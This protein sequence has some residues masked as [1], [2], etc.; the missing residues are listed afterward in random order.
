MNWQG[1][2]AARRLAASHVGAR[3]NAK[4]WRN[5]ALRCVQATVIAHFRHC[6]SKLSRRSEC[7]LRLGHDNE[8]SALTSASS[9]VWRS[10][11][12]DP[13]LFN[14]AI[15]SGWHG[16]S[17]LCGIRHAA[18]H[19]CAM[20]TGRS[21]RATM[22]KRVEN[23]FAACLGLVFACVA[24]SLPAAA[25]DCASRW[26]GETEIAICRDPQLSRSEDQITRRIAGFARRISFGQYLSLRHWHALWSEERSRCSS[27]RSCMVASY[28]VQ[29]RF[30]DRLQQCLD[31]SPQRR[32]CFR[33]TLTV[34][35]QRR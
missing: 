23:G 30:L 25:L 10:A 20:E 18:Q 17:L 6:V 19:A 34:E 15:G 12:C 32:A 28:R 14:P 26:L 1:T 8:H 4:S 24:G 21:G 5:S 35:A 16:R 33:G 7:P 2:Y 27:E 29:T 22:P 13:P 11:P 31:V 3:L 9:A